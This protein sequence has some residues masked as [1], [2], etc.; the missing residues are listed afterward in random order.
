MR[1]TA[2]RNLRFWTYLSVAVLCACSWGLFALFVFFHIKGA[3]LA[4]VALLGIGATLLAT[5]RTYCA[6]LEDPIL[7]EAEKQRIRG[8]FKAAGPAAVVQLLLFLHFPTS[9]LAGH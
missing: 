1:E 2:S 9:K 8:W 5:W 3:L 4:S 7:S 6:A